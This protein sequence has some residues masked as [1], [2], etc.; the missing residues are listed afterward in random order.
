MTALRWLLSWVF[1]LWAL[2]PRARALGAVSFTEVQGVGWQCS[3]RPPHD[4]SSWRRRGLNSWAGTGVSLGRALRAAIAHHDEVGRQ[5][6]DGSE[7][8]PRLGGEEF[9]RDAN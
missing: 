9:D 4:S 2:L 5:T 1:P 3:I 7:F 8:A 6:R